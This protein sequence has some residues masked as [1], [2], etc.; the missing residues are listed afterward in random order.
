MYAIHVSLSC[1]QLY[2]HRYKC[3][4]KIYHDMLIS[5]NLYTLHGLHTCACINTCIVIAQSACTVVA[6]TWTTTI[7]WYPL[8]FHHFQSLECAKSAVYFLPDNLFCWDGQASKQWDQGTHTS[9]VFHWFVCWAFLKTASVFELNLPLSNLPKALAKIGRTSDINYILLGNIHSALRDILSHK[10]SENSVWHSILTD[11]WHFTD[12][13]S[14]N[15]IIFDM[16]V[17][18]SSEMFLGI[19]TDICHSIY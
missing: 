16:L 7:P 6:D 18:I 15:P 8:M 11:S 5:C 2:W 14:E 9:R 13:T 12:T 10:D 17:G 1:I 19:L 3:V 4:P